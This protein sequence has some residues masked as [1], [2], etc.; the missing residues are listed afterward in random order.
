M[1]AFSKFAVS[2]KGTTGFLP[3]L[4]AVIIGL[5]TDIMSDSKNGRHKKTDLI[6]GV[7]SPF[8]NELQN[9]TLL[10]QCVVIL[11]GVWWCVKVILCLKVVTGFKVVLVK[12]TVGFSMMLNGNIMPLPP[13]ESTR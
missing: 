12:S 7:L 4:N 9:P 13:I 3:K 2:R 5:K 8:L 6:I 10:L 1:T 11:H